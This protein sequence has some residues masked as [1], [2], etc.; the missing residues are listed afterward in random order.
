M[1][2]FLYVENHCLLFDIEQILEIKVQSQFCLIISKT[3]DLRTECFQ[4][5]MQ[6]SLH[7]STC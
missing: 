2:Y 5:N 4:Q 6:D 7:Y 1:S 3:L